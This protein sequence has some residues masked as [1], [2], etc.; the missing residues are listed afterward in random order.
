MIGAWD[1]GADEG[2]VSMFTATEYFK[3]FLPTCEAESW[4]GYTCSGS[5]IT[6]HKWGLATDFYFDG[7]AMIAE[8]TE[9]GGGWGEP[10]HRVSATCSANE[11]SLCDWETDNCSFGH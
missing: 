6:Y 7:D 5:T 11:I 2:W 10:M 1:Y 3:V 4:S 8:Q 9:D